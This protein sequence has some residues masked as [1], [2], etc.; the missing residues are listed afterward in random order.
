MITIDITPVA[1]P[2]MTRSDKWKKRSCVLKY[3]LFC[4]ELR[5]KLKEL[6][7][8]FKI[9]FVM[10]M[11]KSWSEKKRRCM[12]GLPHASKPDLDNMIKSVCDAMLDDDSCVWGIHAIKI[13]GEQGQIIID[14]FDP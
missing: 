11:P 10:P 1:K 12:V 9:K 7:D 8:S 13:W 3:R 6:P 2:R 14:F 5:S 4:D